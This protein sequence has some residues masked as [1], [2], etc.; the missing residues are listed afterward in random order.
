[1]SSD[2]STEAVGAAGMTATRVLLVDNHEMVVR[3]LAAAVGAE[4]DL[5]VVG[6]AGCVAECLRLARG[7]LPDVV[8]MDLRRMSRMNGVHERAPQ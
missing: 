7:L 5:E 4:P 1:M 6:T 8:V 3:G 2:M